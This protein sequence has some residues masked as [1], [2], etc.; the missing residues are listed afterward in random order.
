M[1][2]ALALVLMLLPV[3]AGAAQQPPSAVQP[4]APP[5]TPAGQTPPGQPPG[6][7]PPSTPATPTPAGPLQVARTFTGS[8]GMIFNTVRADR[9]GDFEKVLGYLKA[10]LDKAADPTTSAQARGWQFYKV[11]EPGPNGSVLYV[12]LIDPTVPG[13][14]YG[15]GRILAEA[16]PDTVQLT[17]IWKLYTTSVTSGG[18]LLNL[19]GVMP[20]TDLAPLT[21]TLPKPDN[22]P[23][24][25]D[26]T[27]RMLPPN[28]TADPN[29]R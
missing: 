19:N 10:A 6:Q 12:F 7:T 11:A 28:P 27:P 1:R 18:T 5:Q 3:A 9:V 2:Q 20:P 16:Y 13:A 8:T 24:K 21:P 14:D 15:L 23:P 25:P 29:R 17:E 22:A 26:N 4:S